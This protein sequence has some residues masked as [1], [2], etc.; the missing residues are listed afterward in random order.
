MRAVLRSLRGSCRSKLAFCWQQ[1]EPNRRIRAERSEAT[2]VNA[3]WVLRGQRGVLAGAGFEAGL[4]SA[5]TRAVVGSKLTKP[6]PPSSS[7]T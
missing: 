6:H 7:M 2:L 1:T 5:V 4:Y 3:C